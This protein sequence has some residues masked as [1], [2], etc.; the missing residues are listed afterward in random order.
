MIP[1]PASTVAELPEGGFELGVERCTTFPP[2]GSPMEG[3]P[4]Y[5]RPTYLESTRELLIQDGRHV[6]V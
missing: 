3:S 1:H 6:Q 4:S 2:T 5:A